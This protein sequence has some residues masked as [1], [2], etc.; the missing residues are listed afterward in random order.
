MKIGQAIK[1]CRIR[2]GITQSELAQLAE[3]SVSY[4]SMLEND[5]RDATLSTITRIAN[6]LKIP[7][8]LIFFL[9]AES[10]ELNGIDKDLYSELART[11][12]ELLNAPLNK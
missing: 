5:K 1:L 3:C 8:S 4:L 10:N 6:A 7:V 9:G 12:L 11:S 2:R